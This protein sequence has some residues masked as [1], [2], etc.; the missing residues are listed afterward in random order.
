[1]ANLQ[2]L[3]DKVESQSQII[4]LY[5]KHYQRCIIIPQQ[6]RKFVEKQ[7]ATL[8]HTI[9]SLPTTVTATF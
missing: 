6:L 8:E 3:R 2:D 9:P 4:A 7:L 1:M 5:E